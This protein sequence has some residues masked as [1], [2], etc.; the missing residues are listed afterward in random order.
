MFLD[1]QP[2]AAIVNDFNSDLINCYEVIRDIPDKLLKEITKLPNTSEDFY[3]IREMDREP[4][5]SSLS[6]AERAARLIYLNK[7]CYN[8]LF[9]VNSQGQFN[10]PF[11]HYKNPVIADPAVIRAISRYFSKAKVTFRT[12]D[13]A[14]S[15]KDAKE[16]DFVYLDPPYDPVSDTSSFTGYSL[17]GFDKEEQERL[18]AV[19]DTLTAKGVQL[20]LSNSDTPFIRELYTDKKYTIKTVQARRN[21]NS[22]ASGRGKIDEV[23]ILNYTP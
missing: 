5:F 22:I 15:V 21:I 2:S 3:R 10:V 18:K 23:L 1:L 7:T 6:P 11:G 16:G 19:C 4:D 12:G 14:N 8:G 9:R 17:N 20:L 13:F